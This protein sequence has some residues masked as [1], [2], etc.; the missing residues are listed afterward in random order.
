[1]APAAV[2]RRPVNCVQI[3][4]SRFSLEQFYRKQG[5]C[6]IEVMLYCLT[7]SILLR[8]GDNPWQSPEDD[9][10][11]PFRLLVYL[12]SG[13]VLAGSILVIFALLVA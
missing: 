6:S 12:K 7:R 1:M 4:V 11:I 10:Q 9:P 8:H 5:P 3:T 2:C 13:K